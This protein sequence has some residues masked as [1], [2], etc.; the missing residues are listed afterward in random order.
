MS[1]VALLAMPSVCLAASNS[2]EP[3]TLTNLYEFSSKELSDG[4]YQ[5]DLS[6]CTEGVT[7]SKNEKQEWVFAGNGSVVKI[8]LFSSDRTLAE[9]TY[10]P[11]KANVDDNTLAVKDYQVDHFATGW[12][13]KLFGIIPLPVFSHV[14]SISNGQ[15]QLDK[16]ITDGTVDVQK[17]GNNYVITLNST[18][19]AYSFSGE[20][21]G[22]ATGI[23]AISGNIVKSACG[24]K[25]YNLN[26]QYVGNSTKNLTKGLYLVNGKKVVVK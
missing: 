11:V 24:D 1:L 3:T 26:G 8:T 15:A 16:Y 23:N 7:P 5:V 13:Y 22:T 17:S 9:G 20:V 14:E 25:V 19:G 12:E 4:V 21:E 6:F 18:Q 2:D 10:Q